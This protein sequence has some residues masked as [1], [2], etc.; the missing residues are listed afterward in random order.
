MTVAPNPP[1]RKKIEVVASKESIE[2][3]FVSYGD[4]L[5]E[6]VKKMN[7]FLL[8]V[9]FSSN[10]SDWVMKYISEIKAL[11]RQFP[12]AAIVS[13]ESEADELRLQRAGCD[14]IIATENLADELPSLMSK[15]LR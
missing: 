12:I 10:E 15:F 3:Y 13:G 2:C 11:H 4:H 6:L 8:I 5:L 1:I 7:P 9:D 14:R